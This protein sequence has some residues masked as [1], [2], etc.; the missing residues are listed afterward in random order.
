[1]KDVKLVLLGT[2]SPRPDINRKGP[3]QVMMIDDFPVLID[4]GDGTTTQLIKAGILP[5]KVNFL[6][7][8]H[9]HSDHL[10]GYAQFLIAGWSTGRTELTVIGPKGTKKFHQQVL[11]M[12][13]QD[14]DYR[15]SV[16]R[17][18][19]GILDVKIIEITNS[20]TV[21][22]NFPYP[23]YTAEMIHNVTTYG[24]RFEIDDKIVVFSGD[25]APNDEL[26]KL[27]RDADI[28]VHDS[29]MVDDYDKLQ[30]KDP[31][32][33][34]IWTNL[35]KEHC[36]PGQAAYTAKNAN[37]KKLVLTHFLP[38]ADVETAYQ[39]AT[40]SFLGK[41]IIGEDLKEIKVD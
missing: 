26:I 27:S 25:T 4:C 6:W 9:L 10:F 32:L 2:G 22:S 11:E 15:L 28:L 39:E 23:V 31:G 40:A 35:M 41:V 8:T 5:S 37:V 1:M 21:H 33:K 38:N 34:V 36:T 3:S 20:G 18:K 14:I 16:G 19:E 7:L 24:L 29:C 12:F 30:T 17:S 13:Q